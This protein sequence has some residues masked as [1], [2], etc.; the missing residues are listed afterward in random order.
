MRPEPEAS[1]LDPQATA[2]RSVAM[3]QHDEDFSEPCYWHVYASERSWRPGLFNGLVRRI[4]D[5]TL[6]NVMIVAVDC[7]WLLHLYD[8]GMD[9]LLE[10]STARDHLKARFAEWLS[11]RPDGL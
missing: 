11:A 7:R 10:S 9:V 4:A 6:A 1:H 8:G 2:W 5:D 3:H